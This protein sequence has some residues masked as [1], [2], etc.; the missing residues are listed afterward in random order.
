S[1]AALG[2]DW[3]DLDSQPPKA[4]MNRCTSKTPRHA[5]LLPRVVVGVDV[6]DLEGADAM[7]LEDA[8]ILGPGEVAHFLGHVHER[9]GWHGLRVFFV[10]CPA[11][12]YHEGAFQPGDI[13]GG[14][15]PVR[16]SLVPRRYLEANHIRPWLGWIAD[17]NA[18]HAA[19]RQGRWRR[20][21]FQLVRLDQH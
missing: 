18:H 19:G 14:G 11:L 20:H 12:A 16:R 9:A 5:L 21:P 15:M 6:V 8:L 1:I 17:E 2:F 4:A 10:T 3:P 13:L 7:E